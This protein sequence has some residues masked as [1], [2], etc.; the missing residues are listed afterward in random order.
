MSVH[1]WKIESDSIAAVVVN[2][3]WSGE[4]DHALE[5]DAVFFRAKSGELKFQKEDYTTIK[6]APDCELIEVYLEE[7]C[8]VTWNE[9]W[10]GTFTTYD[11]KFDE[12]KCVARVTPKPK[13]DYGCIFENWEVE[14]VVG[15]GV[16]IDVRPIGGI[17]D[18]GQQCCLVCITPPPSGALCAVPDDW[19]FQANYF[20]DSVCPPD[21]NQLW[22]SCF[23]RIVGVGTP[24]TPPPYGTGWTYLSGND[25]W[26]CPDPEETELPVFDQ[27]RDF[28]AVIEYLV[29]QLGCGLTVRSHFF[30]I[31]ATHTAP[32]TNDAYDFSDTNFQAL[33]LHQKSDIKRPFATDPAQ[34]FVWKMNLKKLLEDFRVMLNVFW[35]IDGTDM[36]IEHVSYFAET[37]GLDLTTSNIPIEYGKQEASAPNI[38]NYKWMD[39]AA[40]FTETHRGWP[41]SYGDCGDGKKDNQVN[42]FSNDIFYISTVEN[43]EEIAD[44][45]FCLIATQVV[46]GENVIVANNACL[47]WEQLHENLHKHRRFF[48]EGNMNDTPNTAFLS[49][50]KTRKLNEFTVK[51]C[52]DDTFS[53]LDSIDTLAGEASVQKATFNYFAG[54][55]A[56]MVKIDANV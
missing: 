54:Q 34:T 31:N 8:D 9:K 36:I 24:S 47:G 46:D 49:T 12:N 2:P 51:V 20:Q 16:A 35:T 13:D 40:T 38:E 42:Y 23:H 1:R 52:C 55:N 26:R 30:G 48:A 44:A 50:I 33:Q 45:G 27:G 6:D 7:K 15:F 14:Q 56:V 21:G 53:L 5:N 10:R 41:I 18:S 17:Y 11:C 37:V 39:N 25:W 22:M 29:D 19:C 32:P 43:Q 3:T 28:N 4:I